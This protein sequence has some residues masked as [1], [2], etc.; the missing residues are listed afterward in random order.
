MGVHT[1]ASTFN[2]NSPRWRR[3]R[4]QFIRHNPI[5]KHCEERN[6]VTSAYI[7]DHKIEIEDG[8]DPWDP[9]NLQSLCL[10]CH[11]TKTGQEKKKRS[12]R[13]KTNGFGFIS[14]Y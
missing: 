5:C 14:D 4:N 10:P 13:K 2:Y 12:R 11:N 1:N 9:D 8:G 6:I 7:I 3:L